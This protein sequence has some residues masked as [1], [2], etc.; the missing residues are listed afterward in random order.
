[1][2]L[3]GKEAMI[4]VDRITCSV[5]RTARDGVDELDRLRREKGLTQ[6][7]ISKCADMSDVGQQYYRM[8]K[9]GDVMISKFLRFLKAAGYEM[10]LV[11]KD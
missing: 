1:M 7:E 8:Y 3:L 4:R 9:S 6:M 11:R 5:I 10:M 2:I